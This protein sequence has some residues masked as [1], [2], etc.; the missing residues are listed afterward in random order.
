LFT[1]IWRSAIVAGYVALAIV[2]GVAYGAQGLEVLFFYY[3]W[4][5]AWV[6]FLLVWGWAA[7]AAG[8]WNIERVER[9]PDD[10]HGKGWRRGRGEPEKVELGVQ[11]S[12]AHRR[13]Q[14][15]PST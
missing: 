9:A 10:D 7:R 1:M 13:R 4:A 11:T 6:A 2:I 12:S 15:V 8:R 3:V 14:P 5:F